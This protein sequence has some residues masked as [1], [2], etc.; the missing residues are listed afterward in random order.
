M[1][2]AQSAKGGAR[3]GVP[4]PIVFA[5]FLLTGILLHY[6]VLPLPIGLPA[7]GRVAGGVLVGGAGLA[8][9][10]SARIQFFKTG[11][12][13]RPWLPSPSMIIRGPYRFTRN[14]MYVGVTLLMAG[15]A[16]GLDDLWALLFCLPALATVHLL[17]VRPEEAYLTAKFGDEYRR[18]REQVR[19][20]L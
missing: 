5:A 3:V 20:Y 16:L 13:P 9:V 8:L 12:D 4:P 6:L 17:A 15:I 19:R 1:E 7:W 11:Q 18:Y 10:I 2:T 14:P